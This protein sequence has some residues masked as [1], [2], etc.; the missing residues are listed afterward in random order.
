AITFMVI[1]LRLFTRIGADTP[2]CRTILIMALMGL[3]LGGNMQPII[4]AAQNA[5]SPREIGVATSSV[6]FFR[7]MGGTLGA[8]VF[9]SILFSTLPDKIRSAFTAASTTPEFTAAVR[10]HPDQAQLLHRH[11]GRGT[12]PVAD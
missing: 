1:A 8:A 7:S 5:A 2:L 10:A 9:L 11:G 6:T 4:V 12:G 3:G